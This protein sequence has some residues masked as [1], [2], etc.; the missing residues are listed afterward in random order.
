MARTKYLQE[1]KWEE[2]SLYGPAA[3]SGSEIGTEAQ[4]ERSAANAYA[5]A[6][7]RS[8]KNATSESNDRVVL[9]KS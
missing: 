4:E 3:D 2:G 9:M 8:V 1:Y 5:K 6:A 7:T